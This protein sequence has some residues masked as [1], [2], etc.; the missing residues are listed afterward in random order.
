MKDFR[1]H[2]HTELQISDMNRNRIDLPNNLIIRKCIIIV[3]NLAFHWNFLVG[4]GKIV[5]KFFI[6]EGEAFLLH[7]GH[8]F[9]KLWMVTNIVKKSKMYLFVK[10]TG[11]LHSSTRRKALNL[12]EHHVVE[13]VNFLI[14][15]LATTY[16]YKSEWK[17]QLHSSV[18]CDL[19]R[20][21][22]LFRKVLTFL[23]FLQCMLQAPRL[24]L[25][26]Q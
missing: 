15:I 26:R 18:F 20:Y 12:P 9:Q 22:P 5:P 13:P 1:N 11:L 10:E 7:F 2:S 23:C 17:V 6:L 14:S 19:L 24:P 16:P 8:F 4:D 25:L 21:C 3:N